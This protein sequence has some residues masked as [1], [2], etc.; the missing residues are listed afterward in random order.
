MR[1]SLVLW[2]RELKRNEDRSRKNNV[3]ISSG[4]STSYEVKERKR[5]R[6]K[7]ERGREGKYV[8]RGA[9]GLSP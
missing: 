9:S 3:A 7:K 6:K 2:P 5:I 1:N 8:E 4:R